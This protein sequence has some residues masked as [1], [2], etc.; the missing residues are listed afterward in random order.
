[1]PSD[2]T[3]NDLREALQQLVSASTVWG[4]SEQAEDEEAFF[5]ALGN[6]RRALSDTGS[7]TD[8]AGL[9]Q[10]AEVAALMALVRHGVSTDV[11]ELLTGGDGRGNVLP[12]A[13]KAAV[14]AALT[15][16]RT[17]D[18]APDDAREPVC[19]RCKGTRDDLAPGR[20]PEE[21]CDPCYDDAERALKSHTD[22]A[23]PDDVERVARA[24]HLADEPE[25]A[26]LSIG[27]DGLLDGTRER[28][29][30]YARAAITVMRV[31]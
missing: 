27:W 6:A 4:T 28:Y 31:A 18:T 23:A 9:V 2:T 12:G 24:M 20:D 3:R 15:T 21:L 11:Q 17:D 7:R 10:D 29:L 26:E 13:L 1:M 22:D 14:R 30:R 19:A 25:G 8:D 16:H 5:D